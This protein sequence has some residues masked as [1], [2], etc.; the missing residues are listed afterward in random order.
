MDKRCVTAHAQSMRTIYTACATTQAFLRI[1]KCCAD[2]STYASDL[3]RS[4]LHMRGCRRPSAHVRHLRR[5]YCAYAIA[6]T[7]LLTPENIA[8]ATRHTHIL[9]S[10]SVHARLCMLFCACTRNALTLLQIRDCAG[11]PVH[12][13]VLRRSYCECAKRAPK[14]LGM[15]Y[16][17]GRSANAGEMCRNYFAGAR[18]ACQYCVCAAAQAFLLMRKN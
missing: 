15:R 11:T 3:C 17:I 8:D 7:L 12:A 14:L 10:P 18:S 13:R 5:R 6:Q 4:L 2:A 9:R 16:S 1:R